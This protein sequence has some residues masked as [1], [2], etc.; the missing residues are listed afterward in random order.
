[1]SRLLYRLGGFAARRPWRMIGLWVL[2]VA[3][4]AGLA[5]GVG[6]ALHDDYTLKGTGSQ[7]GTDLL[8]EHFPRM[9]GADA[10]VVVHGDRPLD[11]A[12]VAAARDRIAALPRVADV[13]DP[14][15]GR[16]GRT[17][18]LTVRYDRAVTE[19][20]PKAELALLEDAARVPGARSEFGGQ[21]PENVS[22]PG[23]TSEAIGIAAALAVLFLAF[24]SVV[25]AGLPLAVALTGLGVGVSGI[26][27]LAGLID[28]STTTPTL[29][30]MIG[31]GV[32]I[33]YALFVLTRFRENLAEGLEVREAVAAANATAGRSVLFAG[34][35]V[36]F[37]LCGLAFAGLPVFVTMG[38]ATGLV[39]A[40][41]MASALTLL[42]ALLG[43][44]G[45]RV[46]R[47]R[48]RRG[49][50]VAVAS[51][52]VAA[53]AERVGRRPL[54]WLLAALTLL[55]AL[56]APT[57]A[58]RNWPSDASS[59]STS[60]TVRQAYDLIA[61]AYGPGANGP[62]VVVLDL[63]GGAD[64]AAVRDGL[65]EVPGVASVTEPVPSPDGAVAALTVVPEFGPQDERVA[66][67]VDAVRAEVRPAGGEVTGLTAAY[68]D[69]SALIIDRL[70]IVVLAVVGMSC[71]L[72][73][74]V[75]RSIAVPVK[76]AVMNLLSVG[77][78]Y[79]VVTA[80]FQWG[81]GASVLGLPH[82]VPVS[83]YVLPL[84]FAVL[85][86]IS[87]D[88]EVFLLSRV[89][90]EYERTGDAR[91]SVVAGLAS[92]GRIITS[93]ALI[94]IAVF[95]GFVL[96]PAVLIK[97]MGVGLAAAVAVDATVV[98]LVLVPATMA[99]LGRA[100]WWLPAPLAR[101]LPGARPRRDRG[102]EDRN[103]LELVG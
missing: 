96:D 28:V 86:G 8:R 102:E 68:R 2:A 74:L 95:A 5:A 18:L 101:V 7:R 37:A 10:R 72:L 61:E 59:E 83:S 80:L 42:P 103:T 12:A 66:P 1:M 49:A 92:T 17:A 70:W 85:F 6:G 82:G 32:G 3:V 29:A 76:A 52:R 39:V 43:L 78:A 64:P 62:L 36:L 57:L 58:L 21:V 88:Y 38:Y 26:T 19:L 34:M 13:A 99:L 20:A 65:A 15:L 14:L 97:Q 94:M 79:G 50:A 91:G 23:G 75:F 24:G 33:D 63:G 22:A 84:M 54:P 40:A 46:L 45:R 41:T 31:L 81:W 100:N 89:R 47:R 4:F 90:E 98:R 16:D 71:A 51:P 56:A 44:S 60:S 93:A 77:A 27:V 30:V 55:L 53:W 11:P 67:L 69:I 35:T 9:A 48:E 73:L 87:M 25:A